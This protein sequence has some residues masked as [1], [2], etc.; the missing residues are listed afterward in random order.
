M[1]SRRK[2][3]GTSTSGVQGV[4]EEGTKVRTLQDLGVIEIKDLDVLTSKEDIVEAIRNEYQ[5]SDLSPAEDMIIKSLRKAYGDTQTAVIQIPTKMDQQMIVKQKIRIGW[6]VCRIREMKR[7]ARP[8]RC[9][10]CL[11]FGHISKN[12]TITQDR[13]NLCY[14]C[15][16]EGHKAR[17]CE[18]KP[19]CV[20]CQDKGAA[21]KMDHAAGSYICPVNRAAVVVLDRRKK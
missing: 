13:S 17:D 21:E 3:N 12:C 15:G 1:H 16:T 5:D 4:L 2:G 20:L 7:N 19:S 14:N 11:G 18:N 6:V 8:L 9:Y 10:K